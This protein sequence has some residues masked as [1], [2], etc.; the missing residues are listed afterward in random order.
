MPA[1]CRTSGADRARHVASLVRNGLM[2]TPR[3]A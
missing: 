3:G 1:Y 2:S